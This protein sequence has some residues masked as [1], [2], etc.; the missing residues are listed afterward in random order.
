M[1]NLDLTRRTLLHLAGASSFATAP[2]DQAAPARGQKKAR[3]FRR[4]DRLREE[5]I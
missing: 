1:M 2:T 4:S 5:R 3:R